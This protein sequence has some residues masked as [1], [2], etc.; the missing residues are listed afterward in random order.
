M[1]ANKSWRKTVI[2]FCSPQ[3]P[4]AI[5][6]PT[7]LTRI[8]TDCHVLVHRPP[9]CTGAIL[10]FILFISTNPTTKNVGYHPVR[11]LKAQHTTSKYVDHANDSTSVRQPQSSTCHGFQDTKA[12]IVASSEGRGP[13]HSLDPRFSFF[14]RTANPPKSPTRPTQPC[15]VVSYR[16]VDHRQDDSG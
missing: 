5:R 4:R 14:L 11:A 2:A 13:Y 15:S 12:A 1:W 6:E 8:G 7:K 16:A 10:V 3:A 9:A